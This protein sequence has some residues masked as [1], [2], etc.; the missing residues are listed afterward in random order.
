MGGG[1]EWIFVPGFKTKAKVVLTVLNTVT[2]AN[3]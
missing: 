3:I 1:G 2:T